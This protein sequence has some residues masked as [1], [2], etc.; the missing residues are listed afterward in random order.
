[1]FVEYDWTFCVYRFRFGRT[2]TDFLGHRSCDSLD[3]CRALLRTA[4]MKLGHK[5]DSRTWPI[6]EM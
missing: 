4:G 1:M 2:F 5:T 3:D 6:V